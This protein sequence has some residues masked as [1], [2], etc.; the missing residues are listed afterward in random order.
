ME[1]GARYPDNE[2]IYLVKANRG[3]GLDR[4]VAEIYDISENKAR[5]SSR[6]FDTLEILKEHEAYTGEDLYSVI[7]DPGM[8]KMVTREEWKKATNNAPVPS[9]SG[10]S[11]ARKKNRGKSTRKL[12]SF[13]K[14]IPLPPTDFFWG[15]IVPLKDR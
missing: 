13:A 12:G 2:I 6:F 8:I 9:G 15:G 1:R 7:Q 4:M 14:G 11:T 10:L 5:Q 3:F